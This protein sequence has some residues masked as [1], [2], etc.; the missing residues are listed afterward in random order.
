MDRNVY[1][2][3]KFLGNRHISQS[4]ALVFLAVWHG[5]HSGTSLD[6]R[7]KVVLYFNIVFFTGYYLCF[8]I[9]FLIMNAEKQVW[10]LVTRM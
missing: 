10:N 8:F 2:R 1:K 6:F 5:L 4:A 7:L 3:L 9:E